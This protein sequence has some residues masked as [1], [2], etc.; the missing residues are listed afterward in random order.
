MSGMPREKD[1]EPITC[2]K[3]K[4][5]SWDCRTGDNV[6]FEAIKKSDARKAQDRNVGMTNPEMEEMR[7]DWK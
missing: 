7:L 2:E 4:S 1:D 5:S 6:K 3:L